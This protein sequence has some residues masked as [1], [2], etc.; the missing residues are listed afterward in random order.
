MKWKIRCDKVK[1]T[2]VSPCEIWTLFLLPLSNQV[3]SRIPVSGPV[4]VLS[5][6]FGAFCFLL[7]LC[8]FLCCC[9]TQK[10]PEWCRCDQGG[11]KIPWL[12]L[13][14]LDSLKPQLSQTAQ[15]MQRAWVGAVTIL[16]S[17]STFETLGMCSKAPRPFSVPYKTVSNGPGPRL[18]LLLVAAGLHDVLHQTWECSRLWKKL[19]EKGHY[20][21]LII[22]YTNL[23]IYI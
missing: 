11:R 15:F 7:S 8:T 21:W 18:S 17:S 14:L 20:V 3:T 5:T 6:A 1:F 2:D 12:Q 16:Y 13:A 23:S 22:D 10:T 9:S 19:K 4:Q